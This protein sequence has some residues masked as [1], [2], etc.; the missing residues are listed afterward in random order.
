LDDP[1]S[2]SGEHV[3]PE[4]ICSD[5]FGFAY[6]WWPLKGDRGD[7]TALGVFGQSI[8]VLPKQNTVVG[9]TSGD[10]KVEDAHREEALVLGRA[11][12]DYLDD[13]QIT[14]KRGTRSV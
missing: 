2:W 5:N 7:F 12:A 9:R 14:G 4:G 6:H 8:H 10:F 13:N 11:I 3:N 1:H